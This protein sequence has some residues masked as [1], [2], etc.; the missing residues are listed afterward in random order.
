L[1]LFGQLSG[2]CLTASL[3]AQLVILPATIAL[4]RKWFPLKA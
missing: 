3:F 2:V 1:R 4:F